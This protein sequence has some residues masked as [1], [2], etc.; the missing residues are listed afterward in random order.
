MFFGFKSLTEIYKLVYGAVILCDIYMINT[1][2]SI[3]VSYCYSRE[4]IN[5]KVGLVGLRPTL[6]E[7]ALHVL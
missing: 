2:P 4:R 6:Y 1:Y 3:N 7:A 5:L